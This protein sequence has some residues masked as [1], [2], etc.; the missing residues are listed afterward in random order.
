MLIFHSLFCSHLSYGIL[1]W[2]RCSRSSMQPLQILLNKAIKCINF[3]KLTTSEQETLS[4]FHKDKVLTVHDM[5]KQELGK[6]MFKYHKGLLP[7]NFDNYFMSVSS[8]H[9]YSTRS[10]TANY[11][12]PR[13]NK[14]QGLCGLSYLGEKLWSGV[15]DII[16]SKNSLSSFSKS[17]KKRT[18]R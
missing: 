5:F 6:F 2:G 11:F 13:K 14:S 17:Y 12:L 10:S 8:V 15:P 16:K 3:K 18:A 7:C 9:S 1:C 4:L